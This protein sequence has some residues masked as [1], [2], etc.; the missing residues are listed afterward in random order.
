MSRAARA[1]AQPPRWQQASRRRRSVPTRPA[2]SGSP[3]R[4]AAS[5]GTSRP[6]AS[7]RS[8]A[9]GRWR[10]ASTPQARSP[11]T[12]RA[13]G[14][15]SRCSR[16]GSSRSSSSRS[17]SSRSASPGPSSPTRGC[18]TRSRP[19]SRTSHAAV[20]SNCRSCPHETYAVFMR[21]VADV[22]RELYAE[23]ADLYG[24]DVRVKLERCFA[25]R[26]ADVERAERL[27]REYREQVEAALDGLD[28]VLTPTLPIVPPP[29]GRGANRRPGRPRG[30]D[31]LHVP[32]LVARLA[33]ARPPV[34]RGRGSARV[35]ADCRPGR[36]GRPRPCCRASAGAKPDLKLH[37]ATADEGRD[38]C[39]PSS[40]SARR[41]RRARA[42]AHR[43]CR[44][45]DRPSGSH[46]AGPESVPAAHRRAREA[47]IRPHAFLRVGACPRRAPLRI[48]AGDQQ[49]VHGK[50]DR[51]VE[52][53]RRVRCANDHYQPPRPRHRPWRLRLPSW[54]SSTRTCARRR[55]RSISPCPGSP[56]HRTPSTHTSARSRTRAPPPGARPTA[57]TSAGRA[58]RRTS[59][60]RTQDLSAGRRSTVRRRIRCGSSGRS[61]PS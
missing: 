4:A 8:T 39:G 54:R 21:E 3:P 29:L 40:C 31:P 42:R 52:R 12:S 47:R 24:E 14:G 56:A 43:R 55:C 18:A 11:E 17:S 19:Q 5:S 28:L 57:S 1:A 46:A 35:A 38:D 48:R 53:E 15:C 2:R 61:R 27:R 13:A 36:R 20:R 23:N 34:R 37:G 45:A 44:G 59:R 9:A 7:S 30:A 41:F 22:H 25:V 33:R 51:L 58:S 60:A 49:V 6:T 10:R 32:L 50:L 16:P 26:D